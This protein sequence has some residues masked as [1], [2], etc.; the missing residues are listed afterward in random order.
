ME[1]TSSAG[2]SDRRLGEAA[3]ANVGLMSSAL[4]DDAPFGGDSSVKGVER[5]GWNSGK[6]LLMFGDENCG[7]DL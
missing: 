4:S 6:N 7:S 1:L 3:S 5:G 2:R